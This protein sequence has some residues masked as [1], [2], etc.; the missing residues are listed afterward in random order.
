[1]ATSHET[2]PSQPIRIVAIIGS[3][4][5]GRTATV[6]DAI[7]AGAAAAH[8]CEIDRILL[9]STLPAA[10][11]D[12]LGGADCFVLGTPTYRATYSGLLKVV[13]DEIPRGM[14]ES[15]PSPFRARPVAVV[16]TG[17]SPHH[18]LGIDPLLT[19]MVRFFC[20][21]IVPPAFYADHGLFDDEGQL[22]SGAFDQA[23]NYGHTMAALAIAV[24]SSAELR[25]AT[26]QI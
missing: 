24:R 18:F 10:V 22:T 14:T 20:A 3:P 11:A 21:Y 25:S 1:M 9:G 2:T 19:L 15:E 6:V 23:R 8:S 7:L 16:G 4:A 17:A 13:V 5:E 26:P 12:R